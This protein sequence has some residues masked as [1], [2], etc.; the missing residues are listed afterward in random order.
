MLKVVGITAGLG[1]PSSSRMLMDMMTSKLS[2]I[3]DVS[4]DQ[5]VFELRDYAVDIMHNMTNG[6]ASPSLSPVIK[7]VEDA[8]IIIAVTPVF[9]ASMSGLFKSFFDVID[10][11]SI[12]GK[13]VIMGA[14]GG[15]SR[16]SL[17][18]DY[19]MRP[20][21][22]YLKSDIVATSVFMASDD[23]GGSNSLDDRIAQSVREALDKAIGR[24]NSTMD[25]IESS[26]GF[27]S[28]T[29]PKALTSLPFEEMLLNIA[30]NKVSN[31]Y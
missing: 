3:S 1:T 6:F 31:R 11:K 21:F 27:A 29:A 15:S 10:N 26:K 24:T 13:I 25:I 20:M 16:H 19:A 17:V 30:G 9:T 23:W 5:K 12:E 4:I 2:E 18:L 22:A 7:A 28:V 14:T 8:D